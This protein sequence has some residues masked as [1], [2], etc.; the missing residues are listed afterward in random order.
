MATARMMTQRQQR[1]ISSLCQWAFKKILFHNFTNNY[2]LLD[3]VYG[4]YKNDD[5]HHYHHNTQ[6]LRDNHNEL[7]YSV[8]FF[9]LFY[10]STNS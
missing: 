8:F 3:H 5:T 7:G 6:L 9:I 10:D 4:Q 2:L 1:S